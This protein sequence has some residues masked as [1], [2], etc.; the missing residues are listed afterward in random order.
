MQAPMF[1]DV[2]AQIKSR[3]NSSHSQTG[4]HDPS[5][6]FAA[7]STVDKGI[8]A[9]RQVL[10]SLLTRRNTLMPI[11]LLPPEILARVFHLLVL[12]EPP[13]SGRRKRKLG[14]I[15]AT[16]VCRHWRQV[17]LDDSSLWA[18]IW[19][20][21]TNPKWISE[22]LAR[23]KNAPLDIEFN[24]VAMSGE[25]ALLMIPLHFSHTRRLCFQSLSKYHFHSI[26]E[27]YSREAPALEYFELTTT[28]DSLIT[29]SDLGG[30]MLFKG[31]A[32]R[33]RTFSLDRV[34]IP[35]SLIPRGQLTQL[36]IVCL[37]E[38]AYSPG[39]LSQLIDLLVN[40]PVLEILALDFCLPSQLTEF[41]H[42]RMIDP[43]SSPFPLAPLRFNLPHH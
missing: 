17:A 19:G 36:K 8:A 21:P 25:E 34:V 38:D 16:H 6:R 9:A 1:S 4:I 35:W 30:N 14:W 10:R 39:D 40:C 2:F 3:F 11:S 7:I 32:P 27:I 42:G 28:G 12:K 23:A 22:I 18:K 33:L 41:P 15:R 13:F 5:A 43:P 37:N 31:G 20:I 24:G 26:R 29:F